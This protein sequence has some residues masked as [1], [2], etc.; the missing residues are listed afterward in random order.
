[1]QI[2]LVI[3]LVL[4]L[5]LIGY[6]RVMVWKMSRA[7]GKDIPELTGKYGKAVKK[8]GKAVFY[9]FSPNCR[10]CKPMTPIISELTKKYKN[11]FKVDISRDMATARSFGVM[12]TP[13]LVVVSKGKI[14]EFLVGPQSESKIDSL[15]H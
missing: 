8:G 12:G 11:V 9:F 14:D 13:S 7:K 1:M 4:F 5:G 10:A 6:Q 3:V 15:I 2:F